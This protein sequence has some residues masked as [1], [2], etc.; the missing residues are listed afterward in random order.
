MGGRWVLGAAVLGVALAGCGVPQAV[1]QPPASTTSAASTP[2]ASPATVSPATA[3]PAPTAPGAAC[4]A[5]AASLPLREQAGQLVMGV[6]TDGLDES[7]ARSIR[8]GHLGSVILM[9]TS[10]AGVTGTRA[11]TDAIRGLAGSTGLLVAVDQEGGLV[12]RLRGPGFDVIPAA[13]EQATWSRP[14]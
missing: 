10:E 4:T 3:S 11:R 8:T 5:L 14:S 2:A 12:Q 9:G 7:E 13:K 1:P 6:V